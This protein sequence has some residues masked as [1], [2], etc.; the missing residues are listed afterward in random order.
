MTG[1]ADGDAPLVFVVNDD[2]AFL[3]LMQELLQEEGCRCRTMMS[4]KDAHLAIREDQPELVILDIRINNEEAGL[5]VLDLLTM[6]PATRA[7]PVIVGQRRSPGTRK[8][9][10]GASQQRRLRSPEA[11]RHRGSQR[12]DE[13]SRDRCASREPAR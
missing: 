8:P 11:V 6:D 1:P 3:Q 7:I 9:P 4:S 2:T 10:S 12:V 5:L 13:T